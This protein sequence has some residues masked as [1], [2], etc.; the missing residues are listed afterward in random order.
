MGELNAARMWRAATFALAVGWAVVACGG[1]DEV[2]VAD[3]QVAPVELQP[4]AAV[5][6]GATKAA[7]TEPCRPTVSPRPAVRRDTASLEREFVD[8]L[9]SEMALGVATGAGSVDVAD[10][11]EG[12]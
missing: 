3:T 10:P 7:P 8:E 6:V 12:Q 1:G 4:A 2:T 5:T 9:R 11:F